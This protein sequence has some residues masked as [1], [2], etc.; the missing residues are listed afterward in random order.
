EVGALARPADARDR[1]ATGALAEY[2]ARVTPGRLT[3]TA[4]DSLAG[5]PLAGARLALRQQADSAAALFEGAAGDRP[6]EAA[7]LVADTTVLAGADG[8]VR[9]AGL[10]AG[11]YTVRVA[12]P[13]LDSLAL[14]VPP[15]MIRVAPDSASEVALATPSFAS[16]WASCG[17]VPQGRGRVGRDAGGGIVLGVVRDAAGRPL[18]GAE[19][20]VT[21]DAGRNAAGGLRTA[22]ARADD[23][24]AYRVCGVPPGR[25]LT[26]WAG[27]DG[28]TS[29]RAGVRLDATRVAGRVLVIDGGGW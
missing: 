5:R 23:G 24:G 25:A 27:W 3:A 12:H 20:W 1:A 16:L 9:V 26:V 7:P 29:R 10:P 19:V 21:W 17:E 4:Y 28:R 13:A 6:R 14:V 8:R 22:G 11:R 18:P 2:V 15:A